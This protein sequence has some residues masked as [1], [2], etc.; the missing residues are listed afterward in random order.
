M[1]GLSLSTHQSDMTDYVNRLVMR[2]YSLRS[3]GIILLLQIRISR[4]NISPNWRLP[5]FHQRENMI[6]GKFHNFSFWS[7][8]EIRWFRFRFPERWKRKLLIQRFGGRLIVVANVMA[9]K[10][11]NSIES[12]IFCCCSF[13]KWC[14]LVHLEESSGCGNWNIRIERKEY[15]LASSHHNRTMDVNEQ[16]NRIACRIEKNRHCTRAY[17][18]ICTC[19]NI[20]IPRMW[21]WVIPRFIYS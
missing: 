7:L 13:L 19:V 1:M 11:T 5:L 6:Q 18:Y 3:Y 4:C 16:R 8:K 14:L 20:I 17:I 15:V 21:N 9:K 12:K 2:G 10:V